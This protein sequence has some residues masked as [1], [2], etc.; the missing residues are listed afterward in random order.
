MLAIGRALMSTPRVL[1][2]D[3][4]SLG[5]APILMVEQNAQKAEAFASRGWP[6][7]TFE[8][9]QKENC[10]VSVQSARRHFQLLVLVS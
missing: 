7:V 8:S 3:G 4:P 6:K 9:P 5:L 2:L 1:L 10:L